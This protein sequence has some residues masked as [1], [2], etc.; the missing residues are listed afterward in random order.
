MSN[1]LHMW[2]YWRDKYGIKF[3]LEDYY[4]E[5]AKDPRIVLALAAI[6]NAEAAIEAV[7]DGHMPTEESPFA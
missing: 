6:A 7:M 2:S 3:A 1:P 4:P 5:H